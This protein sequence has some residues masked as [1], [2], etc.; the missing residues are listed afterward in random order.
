MP[1][2]IMLLQASPPSGLVLFAT[3]FQAG[4]T[5]PRDLSHGAEVE[6]VH[7]A[8]DNVISRSTCQNVSSAT[9][10]IYLNH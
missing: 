7:F 1:Y 2:I 6:V 3:S 10:F 9:A 8:N 5:I 4:D